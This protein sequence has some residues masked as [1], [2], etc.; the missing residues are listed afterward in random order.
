MPAIV[1]GHL[2]FQEQEGKKRMVFPNT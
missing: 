2:V 1:L